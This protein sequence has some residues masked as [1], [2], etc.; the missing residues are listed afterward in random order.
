MMKI[1]PLRN[2]ELNYYLGKSYNKKNNNKIQDI[3][4]NG[5]VNW[6]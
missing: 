4:V 5:I 6:T 2:K 1:L 3:K